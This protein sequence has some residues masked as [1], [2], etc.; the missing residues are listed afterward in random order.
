MITA[1]DLQDIYKTYFE[2]YGSM[3]GAMGAVMGGVSYPALNPRAVVKQTVFGN[4][5][6]KTGSLGQEIFLPVT[7]YYNEELKL[8]IECCTIRVA[9][10]KTL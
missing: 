9:S 4:N 1:F 10:K 2:P 7:L 8:E 6:S 3:R 5:L